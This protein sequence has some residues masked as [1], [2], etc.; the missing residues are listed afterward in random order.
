MNVLNIG[1]TEDTCMRQV[2]WVL[3]AEQRMEV[4]KPRPARKLDAFREGAKQSL[5]RR[6]IENPKKIDAERIA[7]V[8]MHRY[9]YEW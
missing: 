4:G 6:T 9:V 2:R 5:P 8:T 3:A 1:R 7:K